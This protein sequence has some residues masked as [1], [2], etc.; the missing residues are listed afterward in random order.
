MPTNVFPAN[1]IGLFGVHPAVLT[2]VI[3]F[4]V[5]NVSVAVVE[6]IL[7]ET[8]NVVVLSVKILLI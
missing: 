1:I 4:E 3:K 6:I 7:S 8:L 5:S 2:T